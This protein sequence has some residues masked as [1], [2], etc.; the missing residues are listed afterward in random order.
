MSQPTFS[1]PTPAPG[2]RAIAASALRRAGLI[3]QDAKMR[4]VSEKPG[5]KAGVKQ[6]TRTRTHP[7]KPRAIDLVTGKDQHGAK[8][9][10]A[11]I[12]AGD[13]AT[14]R[15]V[16]S[17]AAR[18][19][20]N[21]ISLN[22][23]PGSGKVIELWK[24]WVNRRWNKEA[25]FLNLERMHEDEFLKRH[26]LTCPSS[27]DGAREAQVV[28]KIASKLEPPVETISLAHNDLAS[29]RIMSTL[30]HFMPK[31]ANLSLE[32]N[33]LG[34]WKEI[35]Y[36]SGKRGRLEQL[37][38]LVLIGNPMRDLEIKND[39]VQQYKSDIA[40]RFP[41]LE[42]LDGEPVVRVA[43]DAPTPSASTSARHHTLLTSFAWNVEP[44]F[45]AGVDGT[46]VSNFFVRF[47]P[48]FDNQRGALLD[49]Y[50]PDATFSFSANTGIPPRA[51]IEGIHVSKDFPNQR[52][53]E[54][55]PW[56]SGGLGG[57]RNIG[58]LTGGMQQLTQSLH[59]GSEQAVK[60]MADLPSTKHDVTGSPEQF[61]VDAFP[62]RQG[63]S[64]NLLVTV[65]GQFAELPS[66]GIRSF[67]RSFVLAIAP[68]GSRAKQN[69]WDVVILSD[70]LVV[71]AYSS[72]EAWRPG[73][74]RVQAGDLL[75]SPGLQQALAPL[76]EPQ[77]A[78]MQDLILRTRLNLQ[79]AE[80]C[81]KNNEW[82]L[83]RALANYEQV[84]ANLPGDAYLPQDAFLP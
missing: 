2:S 38:E 43:F 21:A 1:S 52:K 39:R 17:T 26:R 56:L 36:I 5:R 75:P 54:W 20:R 15:L 18:G 24:E 49:A 3:D 83:E 66:E 76:P 19:R 7:H 79:F 70:Q 57:S 41:S 58:R 28:F 34:G 68:E 35:E 73:P 84:K 16:K 69:G 45:I 62:I 9:L 13:P 82:D 60:A 31:L 37:R 80:D 81:L 47:F 22:G 59:L 6:S 25:K 27:P 71:R 77:R 63:E 64:T 11:R 8:S 40:R 14:S 44:S 74:I 12:A 55:A 67:D 50:A 23:A 48:L 46:I 61:S 65:H 51:R 72:Y 42:M 10:N 4:D 30:A 33:K 32:G 53:L 29:G 78:L